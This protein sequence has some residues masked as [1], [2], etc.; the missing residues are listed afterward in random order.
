MFAIFHENGFYRGHIYVEYESDTAEFTLDF[1]LVG[2]LPAVFMQ[3]TDGAPIIRTAPNV[4]VLG[5]KP[6]PEP[7]AEEQIVSLKKQLSAAEKLA[8]E[9]AVNTQQLIETLIDME[10]I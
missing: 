1:D 3:P 4:Y 9:T 8:S 10:V 5:Q 2:T 7:T 6:Q